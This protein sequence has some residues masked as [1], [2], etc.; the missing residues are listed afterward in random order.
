EVV[1]AD[2]DGA[3]AIL[4]ERAPA[5][6]VAR[7]HLGHQLV[8]IQLAER[9]ARAQAHRLGGDAPPP[10]VLR[11]DEDASRRVR[12]LPVDLVDARRADGLSLGLD[13][14]EDRVLR[15]ADLLEEVDL[16]I[17]RRARTAT[18]VPRD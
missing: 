13:Y 9:V 1:R 15:L 10:G 3:V 12:V 16:L 6:D 17:Q 8:Q 4:L 11:A 18:E 14:P 2:A 5:R 7:E